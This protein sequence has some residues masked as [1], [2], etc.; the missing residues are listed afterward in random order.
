MTMPTHLHGLCKSGKAN[1]AGSNVEY[2]VVAS[3][4]GI[5]Q[6]PMRGVFVLHNGTNASIRASI[7][8]SDVELR[9]GEFPASDVEGNG[10]ENGVAWINPVFSARIVRTRDLF[11]EFSNSDG[12]ANN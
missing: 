12:I 8:F 3:H 11:I 10:R 1:L 4:E 7:L 9:Q 5:A 2:G 6:D